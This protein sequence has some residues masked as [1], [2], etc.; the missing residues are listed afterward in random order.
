MSSSQEWIEFEIVK[1]LK[2]GAGI[3]PAYP[4]RYPGGAYRYRHGIFSGG[5]EP[6]NQKLLAALCFP[7]A[8]P[9]L[10]NLPFFHTTLWIA[11]KK[12]AAEEEVGGPESPVEGCGGELRSDYVDGM[13]AFGLFLGCRRR[14]LAVRYGLGVS[15]EMGL[16]KLEPGVTGTQATGSG[17]GD[18][19]P[20]STGF[21][22]CSLW[23]G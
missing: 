3:E 5:L 1:L 18:E 7:L 2:D 21:H 12:G 10:S 20:L 16:D 4:R 15:G 13:P 11:S 23:F 17:G 9:S 8:S 22:G 19:F 14:L 6:P